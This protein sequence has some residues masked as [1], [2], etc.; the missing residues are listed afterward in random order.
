MNRP[1]KK[2]KGGESNRVCRKNKK[3]ARR[4]RSSI[5]ESTRRDEEASR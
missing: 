2:R 4:G 5:N 1:E 3:G